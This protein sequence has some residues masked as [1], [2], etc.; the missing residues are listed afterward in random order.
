M[1]SLPLDDNEG[2]SLRSE[3]ETGG[4]KKEAIVQCAL[5]ACRIL[6]MY[7][8]LRKAKIG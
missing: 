4:K 6:D 1:I 7:G 8:E 3:V 5:Q 2:H